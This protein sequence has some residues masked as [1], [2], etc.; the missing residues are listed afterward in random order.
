M[1]GSISDC[2]LCGA[3]ND[4]Q[5]KFCVRCNG[6]LLR[7]ATEEEEVVEDAP[8]F[9]VEEL[10]DLHEEEE[11]STAKLPRW[12]KGS[13]EDQRLSA[14]LGLDE[15]IPID[16]D[17]IDTVVTSIPRATPATEMPM[18]GTR[19]GAVQQAVLHTSDG[20]GRRTYVLLVLLL[21]ATVWLGYTTL[22]SR[23]EPDN[24]AYTTAQSTSTT[25]TT[26]TTAAP[27]R[28]WS[29]AEVDGRFGSAFVRAELFACTA[30]ANGDGEI[31]IELLA[32]GIGSGVA[33]DPYNS[34][35]SVA[36]VPN[37]TAARIVGRSGT[38]RVARVDRDP[39]TGAMVATSHQA[40]SRHLRLTD[41]NEGAPTFFLHFDPATN[42]VQTS[43]AGLDQLDQIVVTNQGDAEGIRVGGL[44]LNHDQLLL[45][46][47][48]VELT[49]APGKENPVCSAALAMEPIEDSDA[50]TEE[51]TTI[52]NGVEE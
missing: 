19:P 46:D 5:E 24:L 33:V 22:S 10:T 43:T 2:Y 14:A 31:V 37:A 25:T 38:S 51:Q 47:R 36:D 6:Q 8:D 27:V 4:P 50:I 39:A 41:E 49:A 40:T 34:V 17:L 35:L 26:T 1:S 45:L 48:R 44:S 20:V 28:E 52:T 12:R 32:T 7:I 42:A 11:A 30:A 9:D 3:R 29:V 13:V 15:D 16:D 18:I 23:G 21:L